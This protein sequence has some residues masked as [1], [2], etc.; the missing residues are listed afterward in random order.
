MNFLKFNKDKN[1]KLSL[2]SIIF[3]YSFS[4]FMLLF[5]R[6]NYMNIRLI[7]KFLPV[8]GF[9]L[10]LHFFFNGLLLHQN[11]SGYSLYFPIITAKF[12]KRYVIRGMKMKSHFLF[13]YVEGEDAKY[14]GG[15][16]I[17]YGFVFTLVTIV[18]V[19]LHLLV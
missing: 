15:A 12:F 18:T 10:A 19:F 6:S 5:I 3:I 17:I 1:N 9:I 8:F 4:L 2:I 11:Y 14:F 16:S 13:F 7:L